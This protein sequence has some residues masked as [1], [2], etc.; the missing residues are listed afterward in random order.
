MK[1]EYTISQEQVRLSAARPIRVQRIPRI[2]N[3]V[4]PHEHE[5]YEVV[6]CISGS[7]RHLTEEGA[8]PLKCGD[9]LI[10]PPGSVHAIAD[11]ANLSVFNLYYLSEWVLRDSTLIS[12]APRLAWHF[13][14]AHLFPGRTSG[15]GSHAR[16]SG[17]VQPVIANELALLAD[18]SAS[19]DRNPVLMRAAL[20]KCFAL[21]D[22]DMAETAAVDPYSFTFLGEPLVRHVLQQMEKCIDDGEPGSV[23]R[24]AERSGYSADHL[25]RRFKAACGETPIAV[26]QRRRLQR[27]ALALINTRQSLSEIAIGHGFSD[28]AHFSRTFRKA[29]GMAPSTYRERFR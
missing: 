18:L 28:S 5:F 24:W 19:D 16:L 2:S 11:P 26:F 7:G 21:W 20:M 10:L 22:Q 1:A 3:P 13:L 6:W 29:Y 8:R 4:R 12:E 9:L 27:A 17:P 25:T 15:T 14:G 23:A